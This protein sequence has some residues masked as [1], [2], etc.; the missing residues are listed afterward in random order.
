MPN[1]FAIPCFSTTR[2]HVPVPPFGTL[3]IDLAT[4]VT[5]RLTP[6]FGVGTYV[7]S[8][9]ANPGLLG[10]SFGIQ[11]ALVGGTRLHLTPPVYDVV[12]N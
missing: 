4:A 1:G 9:P 7:M 8:L 6:V 10:M 11:A 3:G 2:V 5:M 12:R